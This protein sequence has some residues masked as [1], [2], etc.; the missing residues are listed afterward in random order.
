MTSRDDK[1]GDPQVGGA[2]REHL[3]GVGKGPAE[4]RAPF[5]CVGQRPPLPCRHD[6]AFGGARMTGL[7]ENAIASI[8]PGLRATSADEWV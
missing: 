6:T 3:N 5:G 1:R 7:P 2:R 4:S 8:E